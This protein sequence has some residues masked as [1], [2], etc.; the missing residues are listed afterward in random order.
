MV[1]VAVGW[2]GRKRNLFG[3]LR[4]DFAS[5]TN[6]PLLLHNHHKPDNKNRTRCAGLDDVSKLETLR[7]NRKNRNNFSCMCVQV[8]SITSRRESF[9]L[10]FAKHKT[11]RI[12]HHGVKTVEQKFRQHG[13]ITKNT[14]PPPLLKRINIIKCGYNILFSFFSNHTLQ[15][16]RVVVSH[17]FLAVFFIFLSPP[18]PYTHARTTIIYLIN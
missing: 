14:I 17:E 6:K 5:H 4:F 11:T 16:I 15:T 1:F 9:R 12:S 13:A 8:N 10:Q 7:N 18:L 2:K 3:R